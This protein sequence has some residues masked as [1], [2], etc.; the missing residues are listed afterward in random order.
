M[1][2]SISH[3]IS[4]HASYGCSPQEIHTCIALHRMPSPILIVHKMAK[5]TDIS[6]R[7]PENYCIIPDFCCTNALHVQHVKVAIPHPRVLQLLVIPQMQLVYE[8]QGL[9]AYEYMETVSLRD[10]PVKTFLI[11]GKLLRKLSHWARKVYVDGW[12]VC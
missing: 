10:M 11:C 4:K 7:V 12:Q 6:P 2:I 8:T 5:C 9:V 1:H 3:T